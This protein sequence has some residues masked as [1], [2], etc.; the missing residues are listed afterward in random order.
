MCSE[1]W[2]QWATAGAFGLIFLLAAWIM[3]W[4]ADHR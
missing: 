4:W 3:L 2:Q 1:T